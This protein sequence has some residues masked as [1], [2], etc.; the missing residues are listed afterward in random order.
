MEVSRTKACAEMQ[1]ELYSW[2]LQFLVPDIAKVSKVAQRAWDRPA[3]PLAARRRDVSLLDGTA[4]LFAPISV[5][6]GLGARASMWLS[7]CRIFLPRTGVQLGSI[8]DEAFGGK[9]RRRGTR[10]RMTSP[11]HDEHADAASRT[12]TARLEATEL[13]HPLFAHRDVLPG[14][15]SVLADFVHKARGTRVFF[16]RYDVHSSAA[17]TRHEILAPRRRG[18]PSVDA[19][20]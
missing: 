11:G 12:A 4:E 13:T 17:T 7:C 20:P 3:V 14:L 16:A 15:R 19:I 8:P 10:W 5:R 1:R 18:A 9:A 2:S 6:P